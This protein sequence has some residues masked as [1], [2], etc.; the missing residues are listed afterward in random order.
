MSIYKRACIH[1]S[2]DPLLWHYG[3]GGEPGRGRRPQRSDVEGQETHQES[4][5]G[6]RQRDEH[7][8]PHHSSQGPD[9]ARRQ[10]AR[11]RVWDGLEHQESRQQTLRAG[12]HHVCAAATQALLQSTPQRPRDLLRYHRDRGGQG[13]EGEH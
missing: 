13:E 7:D 1:I 3:D 5:G 12:S 6:S 9:L 8:I 10:D 11:R 4:G 2:S